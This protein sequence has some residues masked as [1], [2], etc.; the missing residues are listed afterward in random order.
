MGTADCVGPTA[1]TTKA[2]SSATNSPANGTHTNTAGGRRTGRFKNW[3]QHGPD[4]YTSANG[5][6]YVGEFA[7]GV[8]NGE[9][10]LESANEEQQRIVELALSTHG[11]L[12]IQ[13]LAGLMP[14]DPTRINMHFLAVAGDGAEEA[15]RREVHFVHKQFDR[16]FGTRGRSIALISSG[17]REF[18]GR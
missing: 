1:P 7:K 8:F 9:G 2:A 6:I 14:S 13:S 11:P 17:G 15:F 12:L 4:T 3:R 10:G 16:D 18:A 5:S